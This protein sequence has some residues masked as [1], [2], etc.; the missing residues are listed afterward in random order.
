MDNLPFSFAFE[1]WT[2]IV[3]MNVNFDPVTFSKFLS[4]AILRPMCALYILLPTIFGENNLLF[5]FSFS[6]L[7]TDSENKRK[8]KKLCFPL[9]FCGWSASHFLWLLLTGGNG[10]GSLI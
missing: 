4:L 1:S 7:K 10:A 9:F 3:T 8:E 6:L 2:D 5:I